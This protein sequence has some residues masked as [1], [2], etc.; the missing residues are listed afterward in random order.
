MLLYVYARKSANNLSLPSA[1]SITLGLPDSMTAT[2]ELVVP[3]SIPTMLK[4]KNQKVSHLRFQERA[5]TAHTGTQAVL[6]APLCLR[7]RVGECIYE[8]F[9]AGWVRRE[10]FR[11]LLWLFKSVVNICCVSMS[12]RVIK[13]LIRAG[14]VR[15]EIK[16]E[17][18]ASVNSAQSEKAYFL[19]W[20]IEWAT[21]QS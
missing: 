17:L 1:F 9:L 6:A 4:Q 14:L 16:V 21:R 2:H 10:R 15:L 19:F 12:N 5:Q 13:L 3:R 20:T 11:V 7:W 18:G 8:K